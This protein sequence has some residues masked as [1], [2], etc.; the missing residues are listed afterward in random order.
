MDYIS[1]FK[2]KAQK[3]YNLSCKLIPHLIFEI[4]SYF[5]RLEPIRGK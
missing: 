4:P 2:K 5:S 3:T 1:E